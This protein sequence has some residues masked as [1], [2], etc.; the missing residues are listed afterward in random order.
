MATTKTTQDPDPQGGPPAATTPAPPPPPAATRPPQQQPER[1][2]LTAPVYYG[3][4]VRYGG[5]DGKR[6]RRR[7]PRYTKGTRASQRLTFGTERAT[8]RVANAFARGWR[9][10]V[11]RSDRSRRRRKDGLLRDQFRNFSS[12]FNVALDEL[13]R[14]PGEIAWRVGTRNA[15]NAGLAFMPPNPF[16]FFGR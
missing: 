10:F 11:R 12:G 8:Y 2:L 4:A 6:R 3:R 1:P 14:A 9:R 5:N 15:R 7:R 13:G 16:R